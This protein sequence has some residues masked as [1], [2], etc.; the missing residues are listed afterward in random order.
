MAVIHRVLTLNAGSSSLKAAIYDVDESPRVAASAQVDRIGLP[1]ARLRTFDGSG[2]AT[3]ARIL[4]ASEH[5]AALQAVLKWLDEDDAGPRVDA[6][7]H[8][9]VHGGDFSDPQIVT[10]DI[11]AALRRLL[12][13]DPEHLP[14]TLAAIETIEHAFP[15][16]PQVACFDTAFHRSMPEVAQH[17]PLPPRFHEAGVRRFGFHGLSCEYIVSA[18]RDIA[19]GVA[20][21][22]VIIAHL[23]SGAS[24]TAVRHGRSVD[25][26]MGF[27]PAGG[28]MMGTRTGDLDPGV[29]LYLVGQQGVTASELSRLINRES[30]LLGVSGTSSDMR[31]LL[32]QEATDPRAALAISLFCHLARRSLGALIATLGGLDTLVFTG[33]IGEHSAAV[34]IRITNGLDELGIAVDAGRNED[35]AAVVSRDA[36]RATVRVITTDED[37]VLARHARRLL[38][39]NKASPVGSAHDTAARRA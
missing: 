15:G 20:D 39:A 36:S 19:P 26:T 14:Q 12:P 28:L 10:P 23:G 32:A 24:M 1:D 30:G 18:L 8:R 17:Y 38:G 27:S 7:A 13:I 29:M 9:L 33:G 22:R 37:V 2:K 35:N 25:T 6:V 31:D 21:G 11:R 16:V 3:G 34:R 5:A 4:A